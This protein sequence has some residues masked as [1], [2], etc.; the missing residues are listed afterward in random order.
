MKPI[1]EKIKEIKKCADCAIYA[2]EN[3]T[4]PEIKSDKDVFKDVINAMHIA[5][6]K[7]ALSNAYY[8]YIL[9]AICNGFSDGEIIAGIMQNSNKNEEFNINI[10]SIIKSLIEIKDSK[11]NLSKPIYAEKKDDNNENKSSASES[12]SADKKEINRISAQSIA[13]V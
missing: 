5:N 10:E 8:N 1:E 11:I 12:I 4:R 6:N 2:M 3:H 7:N 13:W 9:L